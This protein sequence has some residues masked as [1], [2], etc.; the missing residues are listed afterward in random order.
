MAP[1]ELEKLRQE[2][3]VKRKKERAAKMKL[4]S[5]IQD[6]VQ[7]ETDNDYKQASEMYEEKA[8]LAVV[9]EMDIKRDLSAQRSQLKL[10]L[11]ARKKNKARN[12]SFVEEIDTVLKRM[13]MSTRASSFIP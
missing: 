6:A 2:E 4:N 10:R 11:E 1:D 5:G 9:A 12:G 7:M 8:K 3:M 13:P